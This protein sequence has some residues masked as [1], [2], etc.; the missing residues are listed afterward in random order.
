MKSHPGLCN[1]TLL[2]LAT[3]LVLCAL[4]LPSQS[5]ALTPA[6]NPSTWESSSLAESEGLPPSEAM[7]ALQ[8]EA[9]AP[10]IEP[11]IARA[12]SDSFAGIW[13]DESRP[14]AIVVGISG[15]ISKSQ[16]QSVLEV[17]ADYGLEGFLKLQPS[18]RSA[19]SVAILRD[20][21]ER[22]VH[23]IG[24]SSV[25]DQA[26]EISSD[27][28]NGTVQVLEFKG[29]AGL[30]KAR[31]LASELEQEFSNGAVSVVQA[32]GRPRKFTVE[33][34]LFFCDTPLRGN[35]GIA[36]EVGGGCTAGFYATSRGSVEPQLL[37]AG[38]CA[39]SAASVFYEPGVTYYEPGSYLTASAAVP[40]TFSPIGLAWRWVNGT[41]G[42]FGLI[43]IEDPTAWDPRPWIRLRNGSDCSSGTC[44][45]ITESFRYWITADAGSVVGMRVCAG[46][47]YEGRT[48]CSKVTAVGV[49]QTFSDGT[50]VS[51]LGKTSLCAKPGDS[52]APVFSLNTARGL[53]VGGIPGSC[54]TYY[55]GVGAAENVL[56]VDIAHA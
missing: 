54:T 53:V 8:R 24:L 32:S 26:V 42:D 10:L 21:V 47:P 11:A 23:Q 4:V 13:I 55:Q 43:A 35:V 40:N 20:Q 15:P 48:H 7:A 39:E 9:K 18:P 6:S 56:G 1:S 19:R 51:G 52:G 5:S 17:A 49:T 38:H 46:G 34:S 44:T 16:R 45:A 41:D 36:N 22:S 3:S 14:G 28:R 33:C 30:T 25:G 29:A 31:S 12:L 50:T 37:T 27:P 2:K